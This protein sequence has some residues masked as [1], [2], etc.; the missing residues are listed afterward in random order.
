MQPGC[1]ASSRRPVSIGPAS[2]TAK[3]AIG[4]RCR[5]PGIVVC[6]RHG[7]AN[8]RRQSSEHDRLI[9]PQMRGSATRSCE[10]SISAAASSVAGS[11][12]APCSAVGPRRHRRCIATLLAQDAVGL[13]RQQVAAVGMSRSRRRRASERARHRQLI[14]GSPRLAQCERR[15]RTA[16]EARGDPARR[17]KSPC[18][19]AAAS[20]MLRIA[21]T[22]RRRSLRDRARLPG[23]VLMFTGLRASTGP[24]ELMQRAV[25]QMRPRRR[26]TPAMDVCRMAELRRQRRSRRGRFG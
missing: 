10:R 22:G 17:R 11:A 13:T 7:V 12:M 14:A 16:R 3:V 26:P 9:Q 1:D 5:P 8:D 19:P 23:C 21:S 20:P 18:E 25:Q 2:A 4:A 15:H 24:C 6:E